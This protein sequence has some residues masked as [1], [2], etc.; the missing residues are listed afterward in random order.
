[1]GVNWKWE[2]WDLNPGLTPPRSALLTVVMTHSRCVIYV[3]QARSGQ[4]REGEKERVLNAVDC[5]T[6]QSAIW[7]L[8]DCATGHRLC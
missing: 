5:S 3:N 2:S 8:G 6:F 7:L 1:M 4:E